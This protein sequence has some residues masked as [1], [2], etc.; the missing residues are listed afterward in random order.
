MSNTTTADLSAPPQAWPDPS[1]D[2]VSLIA[3]ILAPHIHRARAEQRA[4]E[5]T[6]AASAR[7][8][9]TERIAA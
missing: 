1:T 5:Q 6:P 9:R 8:S 7:R 3:R 2:Q 4:V